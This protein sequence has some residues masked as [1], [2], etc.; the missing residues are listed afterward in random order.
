MHA[1]AHPAREQETIQLDDFL[2]AIERELLER[3]LAQARG[4]KSRAA[5]FLGVNRGRLLRRLLQLGLAEPLP[6]DE[7]VVFEPLPDES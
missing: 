2:A 4:N 7:P 6:A 5:Q 3:A 1:A